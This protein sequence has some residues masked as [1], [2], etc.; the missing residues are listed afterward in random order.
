MLILT[1]LLRRVAYKTKNIFNIR[2][3]IDKIIIIIALQGIKT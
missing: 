2:A 3:G 1:V